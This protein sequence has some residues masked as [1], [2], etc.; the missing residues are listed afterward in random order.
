MLGVTFTHQDRLGKP[1]LSVLL[2]SLGCTNLPVAKLGLTITIDRINVTKVIYFHD[3][4]PVWITIF[5]ARF[6]HS[7]NG[8]SD[9]ARKMRINQTPILN[10]PGEK[11]IEEVVI[12]E[13][14]VTC[15]K[16]ADADTVI[17]SEIIFVI[18]DC[19]R[20]FL[21]QCT[22]R[23]SSS[24]CE[25]Q[26]R[27]TVLLCTPSRQ[28]EH[29]NNLAGSHFDH[30]V[31]ENKEQVHKLETRS[32]VRFWRLQSTRQARGGGHSDRE[33]TVGLTFG[34]LHKLFCSL[35]PRFLVGLR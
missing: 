26:I 12:S 13:R 31:N 3:R 27:F 21:G 8:F 35:F 16:F 28:H 30:L 2:L 33:I 1:S 7:K 17:K 6:W 23:K 20:I 15:N 9:F 25:P 34:A 24:V 32:S 4:I 19:C 5:D 11:N 10:C 14:E 29:S 18:G 22:W